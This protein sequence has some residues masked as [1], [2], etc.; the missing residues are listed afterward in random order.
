MI[1][2]AKLGGSVIGAEKT[3]TE[4]IDNNKKILE[5]KISSR[6][7]NSFL[8][9]LSDRRKSNQVSMVRAL[10]VCDGEAMVFN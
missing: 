9:M 5:T 6:I 7:I 1:R 2:H 4:L 10:C 8:I 3:L